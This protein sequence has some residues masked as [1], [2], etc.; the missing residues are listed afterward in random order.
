MKSL[1]AYSYSE[2][3]EKEERVSRFAVFS[4]RVDVLGSKTIK[5]TFSGTELKS[6]KEKT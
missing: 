6:K 3:I 1:L 2:S 5:Q 4:S